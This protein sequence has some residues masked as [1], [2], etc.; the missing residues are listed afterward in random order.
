LLDYLNG[1]RFPEGYR[2]LADARHLAAGRSVRAVDRDRSRAERRRRV[3]D[4]VVTQDGLVGKVSRTS[5][6]PRA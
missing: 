1:P 6:G 2:G 5:S 4:P 3:D